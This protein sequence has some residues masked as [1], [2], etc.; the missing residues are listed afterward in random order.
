MHMGDSHRHENSKD[1]KA[2][3]GIYV[4]LNKGEKGETGFQISKIRIKLFKSRNL[5][6]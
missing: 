3:L 4:I 1:S 5:K 6:I 2:K